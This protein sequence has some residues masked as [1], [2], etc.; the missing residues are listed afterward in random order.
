MG[1][2]SAEVAMTAAGGAA[3]DGP[4][5]PLATTHGSASDHAWA[6]RGGTFRRSRVR[7][8]HGERGG[9]FGG[10]G[11]GA[12][13][14]AKTKQLGRYDTKPEEELE[15]ARREVTMKPC[16]GGTWV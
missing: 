10:G 2:A 6:S 9:G 4:G 1:D 14:A 12:S 13:T 7:R 8:G 16:Y 15:T 5:A 11:G 3:E